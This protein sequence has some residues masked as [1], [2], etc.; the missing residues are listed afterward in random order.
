MSRL[1]IFT[2]TCTHVHNYCTGIDGVI[3]TI[4]RTPLGSTFFLAT[5]PPVV[6]KPKPGALSLDITISNLPADKCSVTVLQTYF[7]NKRRSGINTYKAIRIVN[8]TTA[9]LQLP[10]ETGENDQRFMNSIRIQI[11]FE[12]ISY[13]VCVL[14][15]TFGILHW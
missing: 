2:I 5:I 1:K 4:N 15:T 9:I 10:D 3:A 6:I 7:S 13:V 8:K 14:T 11:V 12:V